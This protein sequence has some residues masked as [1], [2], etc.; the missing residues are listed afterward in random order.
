M[1]TA[2]VQEAGIY[3]KTPKMNQ[4]NR[5]E[6]SQ[7]L[8]PRP[9]FE[10]HGQAPAVAHLAGAGEETAGLQSSV[11]GRQQEGAS[12]VLEH[13]RQV[14]A[15]RLYPAQPLMSPSPLS[16]LLGQAV[17][18]PHCY[19]APGLWAQFCIYFSHQHTVISSSLCTS[20]LEN[21]PQKKWTNIRCSSYMEAQCKR[22]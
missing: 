17:P 10:K 16:P 19:A 4:G 8:A 2:F 1:A 15:P 11:L 9:P 14:P 3:L 18:P 20:T 6:V 12:L 22:S 5:L 13:Q 7:P 21:S